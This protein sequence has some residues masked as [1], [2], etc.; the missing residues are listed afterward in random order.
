MSAWP[1]GSLLAE[2]TAEA[3][4]ALLCLG[5]HREVGSGHV[6]IR[7]GE[8]STHV[9][10]LREAYVKVTAGLENGREALINIRAGGDV[11]GELSALDGGPR[12]ATVTT[13]GRARVNTIT[14]K[15]F[16]SFLRHY[17]EAALALASRMACQ[18][19]FATRRRADFTGCQVATRLARVLV[20]IAE[21]YGHR[22]SAGIRFAVTL[23]QEELGAMVGAGEDAVHRELRKLAAQ[24]IVD[25]KYRN[26]TILD[27]H[28]LQ[29]RARPIE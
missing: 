4:E 11:V 29:Q 7:E 20:E 16:I 3:R 22:T 15:D 17:P 19:R 2:L 27:M 21:T 28:R 12:S 23:T 25:T 26:I 5:T 8:D 10:L 13:C 6:L 1:E 9:V 18:L 24:A 14:R